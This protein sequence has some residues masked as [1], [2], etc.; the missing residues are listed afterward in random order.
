MYKWQSSGGLFDFEKREQ[1]RQQRR[2]LL[3]GS[4]TSGCLHL[5]MPG[6]L[7]PFS[8]SSSLKK[9]SCTLQL[10]L[11]FSSTNSLRVEYSTREKEQDSTRI[12]GGKIS[13]EKRDARA[14]LDFYSAPFD[15]LDAF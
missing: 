7:F 12:K 2:E 11:L 4:M 5:L 3:A 13:R 10:L 6:A 9:K 8:S 15:S 1:R 14:L